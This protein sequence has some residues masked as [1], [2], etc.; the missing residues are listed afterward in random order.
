MVQ[1]Q[2][3]KLPGANLSFGVKRGAP[4]AIFL[5]GFG[6]DLR[7]WDTLWPL[8]P[9][10]RSY[11]RYDLRGFGSSVPLDG[12]P[13]H[14]ADDLLNLMD[15]LQ[16]DHCDLVGVSMGGSVALNLALS[17]PDRVRSVGL[18]SPGLTAWEWSDEWKMQWHPITIAALA[19][20]MQQAKSLWLAHPLFE[21]TRLS[22][23]ADLLRDEISRFSGEAWIND[24]QAPTS[25][26]LDRL[27][28]LEPPVL[29]L[30]GARD[31]PDFRLIASLIEACAPDVTRYDADD[32]GHLVHFEAP[33]WCRDML[34]NFWRSI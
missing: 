10:E 13:F 8:L 2:S 3:M 16:I 28:A 17:Q 34:V 19:G 22:G 9:S 25:A 18:L 4:L 5:H 27:H 11:V 29:L 7:T 14:H 23:A 24:R 26:D 15:A 6:G 30:T 1:K 31:L 12:D 32:L 20:D 21:T 33:E